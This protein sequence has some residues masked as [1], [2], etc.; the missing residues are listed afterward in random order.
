MLAVGHVSAAFLIFF[1]SVQRCKR[2]RLITRMQRQYTRGLG[3]GRMTFMNKVHLR[4]ISRGPE[5]H[6]LDHLSC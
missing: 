4:D 2:N 3:L 1:L 6:R 5:S